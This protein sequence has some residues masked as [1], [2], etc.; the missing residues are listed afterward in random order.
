MRPGEDLIALLSLTRRDSIKT[1]LFLLSVDNGA[2]RGVSSFVMLA[3][4][5]SVAVRYQ[6]LSRRK[7]ARGCGSYCASWASKGRKRNLEMMTPTAR[8]A[9]VLY[10]GAGRAFSDDRSSEGEGAAEK[11]AYT[12]R[13]AGEMQIS[14][15]SVALFL[16]ERR[17]R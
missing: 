3:R 15:P 16:K 11:A 6:C 14:M 5:S 1:H 4:A 9:G 12:G 8:I 13:F 2:L 7:S 17:K 10:G